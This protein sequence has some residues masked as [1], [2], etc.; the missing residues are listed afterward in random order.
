[1]IPKLSNRQ[2]THAL[3]HRGQISLSWPADYMGEYGSHVFDGSTTTPEG[4]DAAL[5][6]WA[7]EI[8]MPTGF[9]LVGV[10]AGRRKDRTPVAII[11]IAETR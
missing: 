5:V 6:R 2:V 7:S 4:E 9:A 11:T 10:C 8:P 1:M 3:N